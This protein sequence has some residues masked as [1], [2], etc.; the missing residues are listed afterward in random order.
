MRSSDDCILPYRSI[1]D[2]I[3]EPLKLDT[4]EDRYRGWPHEN[5]DDR[6]LLDALARLKLKS[7]R[8]TAAI[9]L[10]R[11]LQTAP[12]PGRG[13]SLEALLSRGEGPKKKA[14]RGWEQAVWDL[15]D[16]GWGHSAWPDY[17]PRAP[18]FSFRGVQG[19]WRLYSL[20][21][22]Y[23][24]FIPARALGLPDSMNLAEIDGAEGKEGR[25]ADS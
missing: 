18:H 15:V 12:V 1:V 8:R 4:L 5:Q 19:L 24:K 11:T 25:S 16:C 2:L 22:D 7:K 13:D 20:H 21:R 14:P 3:K 10:L 23:G 9:T 6:E 17:D